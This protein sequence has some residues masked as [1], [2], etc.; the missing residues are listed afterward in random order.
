MATEMDTDL[1]APALAIDYN[2]IDDN[3]DAP[4]TSGSEYL[5]RVQ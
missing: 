3:L 5:R 1:P 2:E 4:P